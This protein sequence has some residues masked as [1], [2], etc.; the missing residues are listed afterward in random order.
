MR[1]TLVG[2]LL[3]AAL[4]PVRQVIAEEL[5]SART[6]DIAAADPLD[7]TRPAGIKGVDSVDPKTAI[8]ACRAALAASPANPRLLFEMGRAFDAASDHNKARQYFEKAATQGH[9]AAQAVLGT[10]YA[11]GSGGLPKSDPD[12][13]RYFRLAADQGDANGQNWLAH[14][15]EHGRGGLPKS[16]AEAA[17]LY[18]LAADQGSGAAQYNLGLIYKN[19]GDGVPKNIEESER[20]FNLALSKGNPTAPAPTT[21]SSDNAAPQAPAATLINGMKIVSYPA[22]VKQL[23]EALIAQG[24][25]LDVYE[26]DIKI[27]SDLAFNCPANMPLVQERD[28]HDYYFG[29]PISRACEKDS[30]KQEPFGVPDPLVTGREPRKLYL[31]AHASVVSVQTLPDSNRLAYTLYVFIEHHDQ[32]ADRIQRCSKGGPVNPMRSLC[33]EFLLGATIMPEN[34]V[35]AAKQRADE[36]RRKQQA[37]DAAA[38]AQQQREAEAQAARDREAAAWAAFSRDAQKLVCL[39]VNDFLIGYGKTIRLRVNTEKKRILDSAGLEFTYRETDTS[40][41]WAGDGLHF[42]LDRTTLALEGGGIIGG[43]ALYQCQKDQPQL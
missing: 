6:C 12:A 40:F 19:G 4:I 29:L 2:L 17:R 27:I 25:R 5:P 13:V 26:Q 23:R 9:A 7:R 24:L 35:A 1:R 39:S 22:F 38:V 42:K 34:E 3:A 15:Y 41:D 20:L 32:T 18:K 36:A 43:S 28:T 37:A 30:Y 33:T 11:Q 16:I 10:F 21:A 14:F 31:E 8:P